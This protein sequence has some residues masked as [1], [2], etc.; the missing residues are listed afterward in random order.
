M[1][2]KQFFYPTWVRHLITEAD[3]QTVDVKRVIGIA[4][5]GSFF[6]LGFHSV[7]LN[8]S[9]FD[10][11]AYGIGLGALLT[12]VGAAIGLGRSGERPADGQ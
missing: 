8:H 10:A 11:Q 12:A 7:V 1:T 6:Y 3:N 2:F 5:T 4:G 9:P